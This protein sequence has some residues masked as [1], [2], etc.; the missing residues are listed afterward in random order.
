[1]KKYGVDPEFVAAIMFYEIFDMTPGERLFDLFG[2]IIRPT[3]S[4]RMQV[5]YKAYKTVYPKAKSGRVIV[6]LKMTNDEKNVDAGVKYIRHLMDLGKN[7]YGLR[8]EDL[9]LKVA[10]SYTATPFAKRILNMPKPPFKEIMEGNSAGLRGKYA[11]A[12]YAYSVRDALWY[13]RTKGIFKKSSSSPIKG[14]S[15]S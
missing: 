3:T 4:G 7:K 14:M 15:I 8:G 12:I 9:M 10:G 2:S 5:G 11:P 1:A 6:A 13:I